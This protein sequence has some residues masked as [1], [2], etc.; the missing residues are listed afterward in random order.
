MTFRSLRRLAACV[1]ALTTASAGALHAQPASSSCRLL[2]VA[3]LEAAIGG[4]VSEK[5]SGSVQAV[6]GMTLDVCSLVISNKPK[7][8]PITISVVTNLGMDGTDAIAIRNRGTARE[9]Q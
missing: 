9:Q 6:P 1:A 3:E 2:Q 5:P 7:V 4:T 8:H